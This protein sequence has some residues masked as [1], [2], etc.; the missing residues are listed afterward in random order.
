MNVASAAIVGF[1]LAQFAFAELIKSG[2]L[3]K[4]QCGIVAEACN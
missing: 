4:D 1:T 3:P 2:I